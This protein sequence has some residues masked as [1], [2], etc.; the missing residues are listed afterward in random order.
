MAPCRVTFILPFNDSNK[1]DLDL[2]NY[3]SDF[4][5]TSNLK[6]KLE[7]SLDKNIILIEDNNDPSNSKPKLEEG[8]SWVNIKEYLAPLIIIELL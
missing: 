6:D 1:L 4:K 8:T 3:N 5:D 2:N 7:L